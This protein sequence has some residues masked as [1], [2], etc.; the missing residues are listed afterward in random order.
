MAKDDI[1]ER[2]AELGKRQLLN[3]VNLSSQ[4]F[5]TNP[6]FSKVLGDLC[7]CDVFNGCVGNTDEIQVVDAGVGGLL[8]RFAEE[9][10][11]Q[12]LDTHDNWNEW[13]EAS[14]CAGRTRVLLTSESPGGMTKHG[15]NFVKDSTLKVS[16]TSA[17]ALSR[18]M[19]VKT[20]G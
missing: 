6:Q 20:I 12:W 17:G 3:C 8:K 18:R 19:A 5:K 10:Q 2:D 9:I 14:L 7:N 4:T 16:L 11:T 1:L 13:Q 15:R